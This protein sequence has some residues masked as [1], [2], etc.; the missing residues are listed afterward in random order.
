M[1]DTRPVFPGAVGIDLGTTYSCVAVW[2]NERVEIIPNDQGNR[3]TPSIVAFTQHERLVGDAARNQMAMNPQNTVFD[4][5]RLIGRKFADQAV[6]EDCEMFP[7][8][9]VPDGEDRPIIQVEFK[10]ETRTFRP[11]E[12]SSMVLAKMKESAEAFLASKVDRAVVTCPAYFSDAQRCATRDAGTIA[13]LEVLRV[14]NEP[15][16]AAIAYGLD[17]QKTGE[18]NVLIF[19]LGG[20][21]FDVSLL[22]M[23]SGIFEVR[24]TAG[25]T[26]LG[27]EDFDQRMVAYFCQELRLKHEKDISDNPRALRRL[28]TACER[29]KRALSAAMNTTV[30]IDSLVDGIDFYSSITRARFEELCR[31]LFMQCLRP[32]E[33]VLEDSGM[34][35]S[36]VTDVVLVGGSTRIPRVQ[37]LV[38][39]F[40]NGKELSKTINPDEAVAYGA[41]V[42]ASILG[43][44]QSERTAGLLLLD[45]T[46]L[47]LGLET[48]GGAMTVMFPRNTQVPS[49]ERRVFSTN[50]DYQKEVIVNVY[51][52]ER[53]FVRDN[54]L[55]GTFKL[56]GI[57]LLRR[58]EPRIEVTFDVN[59]SGILSVTAVDVTG[60]Q[61]GQRGSVTITNDAARLSHTEIESMVQDAKRFEAED[62]AKRARVDA[63]NRLEHRAFN[64][65]A[66]VQSPDYMSVVAEADRAT[67][68]SAAG[69]A[70]RYLES[71]SD[72]SRSP[73]DY[74]R[75]LSEL[76]S[77]VDA[78]MTRATADVRAKNLASGQ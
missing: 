27:G 21:T 8:T 45:V 1:A 48:T 3:T 9:V 58:G 43:G 44:V 54:H 5:K 36:T 69:A 39:E 4:A 11:E 32:V 12:I 68:E 14:I 50:A 71:P 20:G 22:N 76:D 17:Q 78:I 66:T 19:D 62:R 75:Q 24:A 13:G 41:A 70:L 28:R 46:P 33:R 57:P 52:G 34:P 40:F 16:A 26:H 72:A 65:R 60:G 29:A 25:N 38:Q 31:D 73:D 42:Q 7:F 56:E 64:L 15:T 74:E 35:K 18:R 55:L 63:R 77:V 6:R 30:E 23:E 53:Q 10:G 49:M 59:E 2:Q 47:T 51:E 37:Q 61:V 67:V